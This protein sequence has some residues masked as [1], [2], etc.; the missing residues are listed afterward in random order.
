MRSCS[1]RAPSAERLDSR[2]RQRRATRDSLNR[3]T[4]KSHSA[5]QVQIYEV[6]HGRHGQRPHHWTADRGP[7]RQRQ[8][9]A[10]ER[11]R[12]AGAD[13]QIATQGGAADDP[14]FTGGG[15]RVAISA[16]LGSAQ[17]PFQVEAEFWFQPISYRWAMNL[18]AYDAME[19]Q[20]F[21][22]YYDTMSSG[23]AVM[24]GR[25]TAAFDAL[26]GGLRPALADH[27]VDESPVD[28]H[29]STAARRTRS[30]TS[31]PPRR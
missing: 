11:F 27:E 12:Q 21:T 24:V 5:D 2:Q 19:P 20:R 16:P 9:P 22:G 31:S 10:A 8:P 4:R 29:A 30:P 17:G 26:A 7:V 14:D 3:T 1:N 15:D 13:P 28:V 23:S 18:K 25:A 6:D